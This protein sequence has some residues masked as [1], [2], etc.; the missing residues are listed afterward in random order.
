MVGVTVPHRVFIG[1]PGRAAEAA[2]HGECRGVD[3]LLI[4]ERGRP[5][6]RPGIDSGTFEFEVVDSHFGEPGQLF[7]DER[8]RRVGQRQAG[9]N[10]V[11]EMGE[12]RRSPRK[13]VLHGHIPW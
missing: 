7:V 12:L 6:R 10:Q 11:C 2:G 3:N 13:A 8:D 5:A 9:P 4:V 1:A